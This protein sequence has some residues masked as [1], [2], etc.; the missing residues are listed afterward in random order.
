[1]INEVLQM[2][3]A[4]D[5][6]RSHV[7]ISVMESMIGFI[8]KNFILM[9]NDAIFVDNMDFFQE[10]TVN[11]DDSEYVGNADA[12]K[13]TKILDDVK[14]EIKG[15]E[16]KDSNK[17]ISILMFIPRL[18]IAF[19]N[20]ILN[21]F[22]KTDIGKKLKDAGEKL[23]EGS[24]LS[25]QVRI[26]QINEEFK[27]QFQCY[28]DKDS[29]KV[30]FKK[31]EGDTGLLGTIVDI[32]NISADAIELFESISSN[33]D[34]GNPSE[35]R[36]LIV[37][38]NKILKGDKTV[39]KSD[40]FEG[41]VGAL[42]EAFDNCKKTSGLLVT[43]GDKIK[44]QF[45]KMY[46]SEKIK[47]M[48]DKKRAEALKNCE[49]LTSKITQIVS[50]VSNG[51][52]TISTPVMRNLGRIC[53]H[54]EKNKQFD[55]TLDRIIIENVLDKYFK[56]VDFESENPKANGESDDAYE[57]R[58]YNIKKTRAKEFITSHDQPDGSNPVVSDALSGITPQ[59]V[60][61]YISNKSKEAAEQARQ[62]EKTIRK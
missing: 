2:I 33:F 41:G 6:T 16:K 59:R 19:C 51:V 60:K 45:Q 37:K 30:K 25:K 27:G 35:I 43:M 10:A 1:M 26:N 4:I 32:D 39:K 17:L 56:N 31:E 7:E 55:E 15:K 18:V 52:S 29:G 13:K 11:S 24:T 44:Y 46:A 14:K 21:K 5:D 50:K 47:N 12:K 36:S 48:P 62:E 54:I 61:E 22:S 34:P 42:G 58:I 9:E 49:E 28:L 40:I 23:N 8:D 57:T 20:S 3:D 53:D 38:C